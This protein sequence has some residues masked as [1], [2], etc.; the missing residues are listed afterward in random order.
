MKIDAA[1]LVRARCNVFF[2]EMMEHS[3]ASDFL[4]DNWLSEAAEKLSYLSGV[5]VS[6]GMT[7]E[8]FTSELRP[9]RRVR[10]PGGI[11]ALNV[12]GLRDAPHKHQTPETG[13]ARLLHKPRQPGSAI[14]THHLA[15]LR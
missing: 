13:L 11:T 14:R 7:R 4:L 6:P 8:L 12:A 2:N 3:G 5:K 15:G 1:T 9:R 10:R